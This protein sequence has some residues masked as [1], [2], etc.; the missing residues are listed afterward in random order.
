MLFNFAFATLFSSISA[1][2][3]L[4]AKLSQMY[5]QLPLVYHTC[6]ISQWEYCFLF[7]SVNLFC[8]SNWA[9]G[10]VA[11]I[12]TVMFPFW[13]FTYCTY[14]FVC[15]LLVC[16]GISPYWTR[17][18]PLANSYLTLTGLSRCGPCV[19]KILNFITTITEDICSSMQ[20]LHLY[21]TV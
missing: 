2:H 15:F 7:L 10:W 14:V 8:L 21:L 4:I 13:Y 18:V 6:S 11:K 17:C 12:F 19:F 1:C 5:I 9:C 20:H 16:M 3:M